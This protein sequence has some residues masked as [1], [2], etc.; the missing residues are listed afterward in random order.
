MYDRYGF[1]IIPKRSAGVLS[2]L[3]WFLQEVIAGAELS[4]PVVEVTMLL[5]EIN[6]SMGS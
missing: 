4:F 1:L 5:C 6:L 2:L 3:V